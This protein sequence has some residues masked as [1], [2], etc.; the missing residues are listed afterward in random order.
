MPAQGIAAAR[1]EVCD[2]S[3]PT[4]ES[5]TPAIRTTT[6]RAAALVLFAVTVAH[7]ALAAHLPLAPDETYYWEWSRNLD[8]GYYDQGPLVAW[9]IRAFCFVFGDTVLGI[10]MGI[11]LGALATRALIWQLARDLYGP[12][13]AFWALVFSSVMLFSTV[14][15]VIATY[16]P[17]VALFWAAACLL[18]ARAVR[19]GSPAAWMALGAAFG[20]GM[21]AKHTMAFF[22]IGFVVYLLVRP[23]RRALLRTKE[24]Y[25]ALLVGL[26]LYAPNLVWQARHDWMTF[27][28]VLHLSGRGAARGATKLVGE[29]IGGQAGM[30][31]PLLFLG[32]IY[33]LGWSVRRGLQKVGDAEAYL[34]CQALPTLLAFLYASFRSTVQPN[35]AAAAWMTAPVLYAAWLAGE[36]HRSRVAM[37]FAGAAVAMAVVLNLLIAVPDLRPVLSIRLPRK[38]DHMRILYGGEELATA[39]QRERQAM[40]AA[41]G[42]RVTVGA[43]TY[44]NASRLSFYLPGQPRAYC[45]FL[46]T[47]ANSYLVF[48]QHNRPAPGSNAIV[49]DDRPPTDPWLPAYRDIYERVE[50]VPDAVPILRPRLYSEPARVYHLY[51]CY[52]YKPNQPAERP[53]SE[54][55]LA[56]EP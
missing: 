19:T 4:A 54:S 35:W 15:G 44:D 47:R 56:G 55:R 50:P 36:T 13:V 49:A 24:P 43:A 28:H 40:E 9:W 46:N 30:A 53:A 51:R 17:L 1:T 23:E 34:A 39:V 7:L 37:W 48:N 42:G 52:G 25:L 21:L 10:R 14:G 5:E 26:S 8:W 20:L 18:G 11:V 2:R 32:M 27:G 38:M 45:Y 12:R 31:T 22:A 29:Y 6:T 16:D 3:H 33:A 41:G